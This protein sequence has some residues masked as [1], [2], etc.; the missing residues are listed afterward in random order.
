MILAEPPGKIKTTNL[1]NNIGLLPLKLGRAKLMEY[2]HNLIHFYDLKTIDSQVKKLKLKTDELG[3]LTDK[4]IRYKNETSNYFKV[5]NFV[6]EKVDIKLS[7]II[8]KTSRRKRG[9]FNGIGSIFKSITGNLDATDGEHYDRLIQQLRENQN[10]ITGSI[11]MQSSLSVKLIDQ[12]NKTIQ[13]ISHNEKLLEGKIN[14]IAQLVK[15]STFTMNNKFY[16]DIIIIKDTINQITNIYEIVLS[17]LQDIENSIS[18]AKLG[19]LH[20]SVIKP[21]ILLDELK[22]LKQYYLPNQFPIN[23]DSENLHSLMKTLKL[24]CFIYLDKITYII[25]VPITL[26][27]EFELFHLYPIPVPTKAESQFKVLIPRSKFIVKNRLDFSFLNEPCMK[28]KDKQYFCNPEIIDTIQKNNPCEIESINNGNVSSC[29]PMLIYSR[30][31]LT[32]RLEN[33]NQWIIVIPK[34]QN[35][36]FSCHKQ[37]ETKILRGTYLIEI[38]TGCQITAGAK[39]ITNQET[40]RANNQPVLLPKIEEF[41]SETQQ[42]VPIKVENILLEDLGHLRTQFEASVPELSAV[43]DYKP[44]V[45]TLFIIGLM[46]ASCMCLLVSKLRSRTQCG[47]QPEGLNPSDVQL[48]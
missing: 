18:F 47:Q 20:P 24:D 22:S 44:S 17:I 28:L 26:P 5:L 39:R 8:P 42:E 4:N 48:P 3:N 29:R 31:L 19:I 40:R 27:D 45:W 33:T 43:I 9:L 36:K 46:I 7:E 25:Y 12:F 23:I 1:G 34:S 16:N 2:S 41:S 14:E 11:K 21:D 30:S 15:N 6:K 35:I 37:E 10:K 38:P 32:Q 13:K